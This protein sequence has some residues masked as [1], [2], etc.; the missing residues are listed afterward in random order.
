MRPYN[1]LTETSQQA[2]QDKFP[3][4]PYAAYPPQKVCSHHIYIHIYT[5]LYSFYTVEQVTDT[6]LG[7]RHFFSGAA[8]LVVGLLVGAVLTALY[9][10][11]SAQFAYQQ[12]R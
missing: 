10:R 12:I 3:A 7:G 11:H 9:Y 5:Y 6:S 1:T 4:G 8:N 2:Y